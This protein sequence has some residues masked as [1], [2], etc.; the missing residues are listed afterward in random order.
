MLFLFND[1]VFDLGDLKSVLRGEDMPLD[2]AQIEALTPAQ[3]TTLAREAVFAD[4]NV[5]HTR[6]KHIRCL[7]A[8][9]AYVIPGSNAILVVRPEGAKSW[10]EVGV[11]FAQVPIETLA[12]LWTAQQ[13]K[14][15]SAAEVNSSVWTRSSAPLP[16]ATGTG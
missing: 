4:P 12:F 3:L 9:M 1:V 11:R 10:I 5:A 13:S 2:T 16:H 15:L 8:L 6:P 14:R 7:V